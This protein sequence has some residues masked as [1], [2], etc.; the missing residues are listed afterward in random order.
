MLVKQKL[1]WVVEGYTVTSK[2]ARANP[3]ERNELMKESPH[4]SRIT[5]ADR[6]RCLFLQGLSPPSQSVEG[7][8]SQNAEPRTC[9]PF[10]NRASCGEVKANLNTGPALRKRGITSGS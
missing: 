8:V 9:S 3:Q 7:P 4:H 2:Y 5:K 10:V 6:Q 1:F